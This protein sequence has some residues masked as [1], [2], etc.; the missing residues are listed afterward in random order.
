MI[1]GREDLKAV[2]EEALRCDE[3]ILRTALSGRPLVY[4]VGEDFADEYMRLRKEKG[5]HLKSLRFSSKDVDLERHK[6]HGKYLKEVR[7]ADIRLDASVIIW[8]DAVATVDENLNGIV[9]R[10]QQ[11]AAVMK[12]WFD[13]I[14]NQSGKMHEPG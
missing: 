1:A 3:K 4:F 14:W 6:A 12:S 11:H 5:V 7:N 8:D 9:I 2:L 10:N 13:Y